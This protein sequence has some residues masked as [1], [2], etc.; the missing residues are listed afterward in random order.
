M[1]AVELIFFRFGVVF[2]AGCVCL[3]AYLLVCAFIELIEKAIYEWRYRHRFDGKPC[4]KCWCKDCEMHGKND[5]CLLPGSSRST[6]DNGFC[7]EARPRDKKK[8]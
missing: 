7:Y 4:A 5:R 6:P 2:V 1:N 8:I 3:F